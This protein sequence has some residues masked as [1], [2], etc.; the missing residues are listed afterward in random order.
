MNR[1]GA[2]KVAAGVTAAM[3]LNP[4][5][6]F[7]VSDS[8]SHGA[9]ATAPRNPTHVDTVDGARL[10]VRA[11]GTGKPAVFLHAWGLTSDAW[12]YQMVPLSNR[13]VRCIA[14]DRRGHGR[15]SD[16]GTGFDYDVLAD[17]LAAVLKA[18]DVRDATLIG[19]SFAAGEL[20]RYMS[21]HRGSRV[22]RLVMIAPACTPFRMQAPDNPGGTP[23]AALEQ[24]R[25]TRLLRD[26]PKTLREAMPAFLLPESSPAMLDWV[27]GMVQQTSLKA[28]VECHRSMTETDFRRELRAL[29]VPA[30]IIHGDKD[31]SAPLDATG[32]ATAALI[33][34]AQFRVYE[35][36]P[37]GL[38]LTHM[39]RL[40]NDILAF[41]SG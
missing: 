22:S 25:Q 11:W 8:Q 36:A 7:A 19:H 33:P 27:I 32:R 35:G 10:S 20:V 14:Y 40:T 1:R 39:E 18:F 23:A 29:S 41:V 6:A 15:S 24:L 28:L 5:R 26:L 37:H 3:G 21:R 9:T 16:P 12:Q 4:A 30:L 38:Q 17:D 34:R 2:L 31:T 13:G